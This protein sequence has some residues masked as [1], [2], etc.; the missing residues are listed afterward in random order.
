MKSPALAPTDY[1]QTYQTELNTLI[2][3]LDD[4][5]LKLNAVNF[6]SSRTDASGDIDQTGAI[7]LQSPDGTFYKLTVANGGAISGAAVTKDQ[8][9]NPYVT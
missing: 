3:E 7:V 1:D 6:L 9:S 8:S 5:S 2:T 4:N